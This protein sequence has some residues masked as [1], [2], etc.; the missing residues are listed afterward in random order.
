M[1]VKPPTFLRYYW[2]YFEDL[3]FYVRPNSSFDDRHCCDA[4]FVLTVLRFLISKIQ[5]S[6]ANPQRG[7]SHHVICFQ[8]GDI[9]DLSY[10]RIESRGVKVLKVQLFAFDSH[11]TNVHSA[12]NPQIRWNLASLQLVLLL[13]LSGQPES[14]CLM[15]KC[16]VVH[17]FSKPNHR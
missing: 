14:R 17:Y 2:I 4:V 11:C 8:K 1:L 9:H 6:V 12:R 3:I 10:E 7:Q 13:E 15:A 16:E 5:I